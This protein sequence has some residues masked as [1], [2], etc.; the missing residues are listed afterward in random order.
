MHPVP[1]PTSN[2]A[3]PTSSSGHPTS[4]LT[5]I[6]ITGTDGK[7]TTSI[8]TIEA[9][10]AAGVR[11]GGM[12]SLDFRCLDEIE[13]NPTY[14]TTLEAQLRDV[15]ETLVQLEEQVR[16]DPDADRCRV[17]LHQLH[18]RRAALRQAIDQ[19]VRAAG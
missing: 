3:Y 15:H 5:V 12:T 11:A 9:L 13:V 14:R 8:L 2:S 18:E 4:A 7:T 6:G 19:L 17:Q 10:L 1:Y 16:R